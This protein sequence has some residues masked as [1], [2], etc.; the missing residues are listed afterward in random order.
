VARYFRDGEVFE[1]EQQGPLLEISEGGV[2]STRKFVSAE[3][4]MVQLRRLVDQRLAAGFVEA[5][6][7]PIEGDAWPSPDDLEAVAIH[8]DRLMTQGDARGPFVALQLAHHALAGVTGPDAASRRADLVDEGEALL[9]RHPEAFFG[10]LGAVVSA[11]FAVVDDAPAVRRRPASLPAFDR[12][13]TQPIRLEL[14]LGQIERA[15]L[16]ATTRLGIGD[17]YRALRALSNAQHLRALSVGP[18]VTRDKRAGFHYQD[19]YEA[20][21]RAPLPASLVELAIG[22]VTP[23]LVPVANPGD[24]SGV[25]AQARGLRGLAVSGRRVEL[26]PVELAMLETLHLHTTVHPSLL[27]TLARSTLPAL[28]RLSL[29]SFGIGAVLPEALDFVERSARGVR[30]LTLRGFGGGVDRVDVFDRPLYRTLARLDLAENGLGEDLGEWVLENAKLFEHLEHLDLRH[31]HLSHGLARALRAALPR[32][33]VLEQQGGPMPVD[34][35]EGI[36][37]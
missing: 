6:L 24:L 32:A 22:D 18:T 35:Y 17:A 20:I 9:V 27:A 13:A 23:E 10:E 14:R 25:L 29:V 2:R 5:G 31:N 37:E 4:A 12:G 7:A 8:A 19:L 1:I 11:R 33:E 16:V 34:R 15:R 21:E 26:E 30:E 36:Q 28:E 3:H